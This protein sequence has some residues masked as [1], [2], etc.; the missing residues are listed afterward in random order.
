MLHHIIALADVLLRHDLHVAAGE[1]LLVLTDG[2]HDADV[3]DG[4][5]AA[6]RGL[7]AQV[8]VGGYTPERFVAMREFAHFAA[9]SLRDDVRRLPE[10]LA[11]ALGAA[12]VCVVLNSDLELLFDQR[13]L[14]SGRETTRIGWIPYLDAETMLRLLPRDAHEVEEL[15]AVT[16]AVDERL[17]GAREVTV[18]SPGG[19]D[20]R[21]ELGGRRLNSSGGVHDPG[22]GFGGIE[23]F[24]AGQ[25]STVPAEASAEG[26]LVID[27]SVNAPEYKE[28]LDPIAFTIR[29]GRV[30]AIDGGV[31]A[32]RLAQFLESLD[33]PDVYHLT[34]L[35]IG[36]NR[37]CI[38]AG[39]AGPCEDTHAAGCVSFAL[40]AD[41]HLG[42]D[43]VA[44]V[45]IDMTMRRPSLRADGVDTVIDGRVV[46]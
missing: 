45:H 32:Q 41:R 8:S 28:L 21:L 5:V 37:K 44:P 15:A 31:E 46:V 36:T 33:H 12:D 22:R 16:A 43:V 24:P 38:A 18:T 2:T 42:G 20:L 35:G 30:A 25:V 6:G 23:I 4:F 11:A 3:L 7:G 19:T 40:G 10:P 39:Y 14:A 27:R 26:T 1:E 9:A 34:E 17:R 29:E 13:F